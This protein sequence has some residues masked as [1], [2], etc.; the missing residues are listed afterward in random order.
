MVA[1]RLARDLTS[2]LLGV[3]LRAPARDP[4]TSSTPVVFFW[5]VFTVLFGAVGAHAVGLDLPAS[6]P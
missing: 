5:W 3:R 2:A 1:L 6:P 4:Y